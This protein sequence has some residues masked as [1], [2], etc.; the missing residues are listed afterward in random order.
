VRIIRGTGHEGRLEAARVYV[1]CAGWA[2]PG[3][4][5]ADFP[6]AGTH[7]QR[8]ASRLPATEI[9]SSFY[10]PHRLA[11]YAR[12]GDAVPAAFRF[13]V[14][15]P[16]TI[17]HER[18][19]RDCDALLVPFLAEIGALGDRLGCLLVQLPPSLAWSVDAVEGFLR[20]LRARHAGAVALEP[21]H[22]S[23]FDGAAS[24]QLAQHR[25]A[26][27][28]ADPSPG[29]AGDRAAGDRRLT[30]FRLHGSPRMYYSNYESRDLDEIA[31][32][33]VEAARVSE[34]IWCIF[35][36]TALGAATRNALALVERLRQVRGCITEDEYARAATA[37]EAS[38]RPVVAVSPGPSAARSARR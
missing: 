20:A 30:Y 8:Y 13:A 18:R 10:R 11:T 28:G 26:R 35:D 27:V 32:R 17:T 22:P 7:L 37:V 23:W 38:A 5:A 24:V 21:R 12:W 36:N 34:S 31:S 33:I 16:R 9:N 6:A 3:D 1:G 25:V 19:L 29:R 4:Q 15:L 14:K 2:I